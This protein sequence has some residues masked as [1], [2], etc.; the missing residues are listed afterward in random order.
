[1]SGQL[2]PGVPIVCACRSTFPGSG[3][4]TAHWTGDNAATWADLQ[5]S[6]ASI[7]NFGFFGIPF[8]GEQG[9]CIACKQ[10]MQFA[11]VNQ[12]LMSPLDARARSSYRDWFLPTAMCIGVFCTIVTGCWLH[13]IASNKPL[14]DNVGNRRDPIRLCTMVCQWKVVRT[15]CI[16]TVVTHLLS[17]NTISVA[18]GP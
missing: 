13:M 5:W 8:T 7:V 14:N 15:S 18:L 2:Y 11:S 4:Y 16:I 17:G 1:M 12:A 10:C 9:P 6:V 3:A